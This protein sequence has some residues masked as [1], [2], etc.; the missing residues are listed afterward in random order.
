M[1]HVI[2]LP[3]GAFIGSLGVKG[4]TQCWDTHKHDHKFGQNESIDIGKNQTHQREDNAKI[5][6]V[7]TMRPGLA[8]IILKVRIST[9]FKCTETDLHLA[10]KACC[11]DHPDTWSSK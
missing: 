6:K 5:N 2:Q 11:N 1:V 3:L 7:S 4:R 9:Y 8:K 10:E